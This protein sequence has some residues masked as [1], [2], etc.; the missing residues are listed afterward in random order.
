MEHIDETGL[1]AR[2]SISARLGLGETISN[3]KAKRK[4]NTRV[5]KH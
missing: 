4:V 1:G 5:T 2:G 3:R